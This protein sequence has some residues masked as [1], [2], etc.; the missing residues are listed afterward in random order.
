MVLLSAY[1]TWVWQPTLDKNKDQ[2]ELALKFKNAQ[3]YNIHIMGWHL[4][5]LYIC[6]T[7]SLGVGPR[8]RVPHWYRGTHVVPGY[9]GDLVPGTWHPRLALW[10]L[11]QYKK[12]QLNRNR[13]TDLYR[14]TCAVTHPFVVQ[15]SFDDSAAVSTHRE[16]RYSLHNPTIPQKCTSERF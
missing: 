14:G 12:I 3:M 6:L 1:M 5:Q 11:Q 15:N 16:P 9:R 8:F 2:F 7:F 4:V 13:G 10:T